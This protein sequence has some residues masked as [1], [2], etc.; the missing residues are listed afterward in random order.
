MAMVCSF[1]Q[2]EEG[3]KCSCEWKNE[4]LRSLLRPDCA[5]SEMAVCALAN[6]LRTRHKCFFP[7]LCEDRFGQLREVAFAYRDCI[8]RHMPEHRLCRI[9][10]D[11]L[12]GAA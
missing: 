9:E 12:V 7:D 6:Q 4:R 8:A 11:A 3:G 1:W 5:A 2:W 10:L